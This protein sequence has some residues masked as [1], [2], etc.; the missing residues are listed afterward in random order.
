MREVCELS[1]GIVQAAIFGWVCFRE[2]VLGAVLQARFAAM[3][4]GWWHWTHGAGSAP[5]AVQRMARRRS[6]GWGDAGVVKSGERR[7]PG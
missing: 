5:L 7:W 1:D 4:Y 2:T 6:S 3:I